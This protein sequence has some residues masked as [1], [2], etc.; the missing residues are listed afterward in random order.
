VIRRT[1]AGL[2]PFA[3][4]RKHLHHRLLDIGHSHRLSVLIMYLWAAVFSSLVVWFSTARTPLF[5]F[6]VITFA[7]VVALLVMSMPRLRWW[8]RGRR[9]RPAAAAVPAGAAP[10]GAGSGGAGLVGAGIAGAGM[11]GAGPAGHGHAGSAGPR[12]Y[13]PA[14]ARPG[15]DG[16]ATR[17]APGWAQPELPPM[18]ASGRPE[19]D[20]NAA[21]RAAP[22]QPGPEL[23]VLDLAAETA[24][25]W[26]PRSVI[27]TLPPAPAYPQPLPLAAPTRPVPENPDAGDDEAISATMPI[28]VRDAERPPGGWLP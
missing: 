8:Q 10:A 23:T 9:R 17:P 20:L 24:P 27:G 7:A 11:A 15:P 28:P 22:Q 25:G 26:R 6:A 1:R 5:V 19:A 2:S 3:P 16:P 12:P 4:D 14:A 13:R 18:P 21:D